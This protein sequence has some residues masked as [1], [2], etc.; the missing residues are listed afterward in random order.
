MSITNHTPIFLKHKDADFFVH[1][2]NK[3]F[4]TFTNSLEF[5]S[6]HLLCHWVQALG[7][8]FKIS[9]AEISAP[10]TNWRCED[11][12]HEEAPSTQSE[13]W[14]EC[15]SDRSPYYV[16]SWFVGFNPQNWAG[17]R[18]HKGQQILWLPDWMRFNIFYI[19]TNSCSLLSE[20]EA[21]IHVPSETYA[22]IYM[23]AFNC[24]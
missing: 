16:F 18:D 1:S 19:S 2:F 21:I 23:F 22:W 9:T 17:Q 20:V 11:G 13:P 7:S 14:S 12:Q 24:S 8:G 6:Y 4:F 3:S 15:L 10:H 5:P